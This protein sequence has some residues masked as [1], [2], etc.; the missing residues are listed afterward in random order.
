MGRL[1]S[2]PN[3]VTV[4]DIDGIDFDGVGS[5]NLGVFLIALAMVNLSWGEMQKTEETWQRII[6]NANR[7]HDATLALQP[8]VIQGERET[9]AGHL[10]EAPRDRPGNPS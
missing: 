5:S 10:Y 2:H 4:F 8:L 6:E 3:I 7:S 1:G 9:L